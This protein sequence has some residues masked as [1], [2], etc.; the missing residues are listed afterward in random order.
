MRTVVPA[1]V[2]ASLDHASEQ[3]AA[4]NATEDRCGLDAARE[5]R[6]YLCDH[7]SVALPQRGMVVRGHEHTAG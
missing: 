4:T 6:P 5:L 7:R 2:S 3:P 1:R